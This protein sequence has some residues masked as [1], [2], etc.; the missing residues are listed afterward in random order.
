MSLLPAAL[1]ISSC[2]YMS[3]ARTVLPGVGRTRPWSM[4]STALDQT[5]LPEVSIPGGLREADDLPTK[6]KR[7]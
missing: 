2:K 5:P 3:C 6:G 7:T 1:R 4:E